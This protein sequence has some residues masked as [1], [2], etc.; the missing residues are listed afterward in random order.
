MSE[1]VPFWKVKKL[2]EISITEWESLCDGCG[3]CCLHKVEDDDT[4]DIYATSVACRLL[5]AETCR[6]RDYMHR[7]SIVSDCILLDIATIK[8]ARWLPE[9]CA[10]RL[11]YEGQDLQ[12]WHPL[13]SGNPQ[14]VHQTEFSAR[15]QI[16]IYEDELSSAEDYLEHITGLLCEG[17]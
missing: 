12:W 4:G 14:T 13:V 7:K 8:T 3:R 9:S 16:E 6:C 2:E 5:D 10:Y 1:E 15:G 11:I 17:R